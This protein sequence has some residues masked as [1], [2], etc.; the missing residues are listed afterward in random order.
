MFSIDEFLFDFENML[1]VIK[2]AYLIVNCKF[3]LTCNKILIVYEKCLLI[4]VS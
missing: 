3:F 4:Y 2:Y 1:V